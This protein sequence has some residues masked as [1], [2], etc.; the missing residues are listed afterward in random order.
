MSAS[1]HLPPKAARP[2]ARKYTAQEMKT[3]AKIMTDRRAR[4][5]VGT[6]VG[7]GEAGDVE[8]ERLA[9]D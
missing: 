8:T 9:S 7:G 3:L 6:R 4:S 1:L 5:S 2:T